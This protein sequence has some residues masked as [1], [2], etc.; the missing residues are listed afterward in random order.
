LIVNF[1]YWRG[2]HGHDCLVVGLQLPMQS[3]PITANVVSWNQWF[4]P[5][6]SVSS[7]NK[8]DYQNIM[9]YCWKWC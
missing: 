5:S 9:K 2:R 4:S 1:S 7:T 3:V 6:T 8:T